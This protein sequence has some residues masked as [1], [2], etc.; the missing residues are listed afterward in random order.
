MILGFHWADGSSTAVA[1]AC[2]LAFFAVLVA[3]AFAIPRAY[4][5]AGAPDQARWRD[6]RLWVAAI[7]A[8]PTFIYLV[9]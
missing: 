4:I 5:Y 8:I 1:R 3:G 9:L 7:M 6:L 2:F